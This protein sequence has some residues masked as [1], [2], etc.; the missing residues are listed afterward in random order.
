ME[1]IVEV[2]VK[3]KP[4]RPKKLTD[5]E[6]K[7]NYNTYQKEYQKEYQKKKREKLKENLN[8]PEIKFSKEL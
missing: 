1:T 5:E 6:R 2:I 4:G 8:K 3:K 7:K